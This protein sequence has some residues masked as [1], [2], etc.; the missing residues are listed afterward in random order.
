MKILNKIG[1][2]LYDC[3]GVFIYLIIIGIIILVFSA[4]ARKFVADTY[5]KV[6]TTDTITIPKNSWS[7]HKLSLDTSERAKIFY[8]PFSENNG[9][10]YIYVSLNGVYTKMLFDTGASTTQVTPSFVNALKQKGLINEDDYRLPQ[11]SI[12]A[13]GTKDTTDVIVIKKLSINE[14]GINK[15]NKKLSINEFVVN[16][17]KVSVA[18][19]DEGTC[20]IGNNVLD[21]LSYIKIDNLNKKLIL[22]KD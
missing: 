3:F 1:G 15:A 4:S 2:F 6:F 22:I 21:S 14:F 8:I 7:A 18:N 17:V 12:T 16:N 10:K 9:C 5:N 13:D 20:L 11:V 19:S